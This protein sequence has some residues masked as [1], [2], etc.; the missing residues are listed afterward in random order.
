MQ[1]QTLVTVFF[2]TIGIFLLFSCQ[3][4]VI[5]SEENPAHA[6]SDTIT[7]RASVDILYT[8]WVPALYFSADQEEGIPM[9]W[10][11][12]L[13]GLIESEATQGYYPAL[14]IQNLSSPD[15]SILAKQIYSTCFD[16]IEAADSV[17]FQ[18]P[19]TTGLSFTERTKYIG[20]A[21]FFRAFNRFYLIR[22]FGSFPEQRTSTSYLSQETAY[23][24]V[25][26]D[27]QEAIAILPEKSFVENASRVTS[28]V[29]RALLGEVYLQMSGYP[30]QKKKYTEAAEILRPIIKSD[31]HHL[32]INGTREEAS[33][34]NILRTTPTNDEHLYVIYGEHTTPRSSF[35]FP[36][37]AKN[38]ENI[39]GNVA[40]NAFKPSKAFMTCYTN[41]DLRGKDRQFFHT[42]FKVKDEGK[43]IFE[44]FDPAPFFWLS[45]GT[46]TAAP[47]RQA[48]G[49]YRYA[50]ILLMTAEAIAQSEGGTAEA[51]TYLAQVRAR[52][53]SMP[54][55]ELEQYFLTLTTEHFLKEIWLERLRELPFEMKQ[56]SDIIRTDFYPTCQ[57]DTIC[58]VP[59]QEAQTPKGNP[60]NK[61]N[62]LLPRPIP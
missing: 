39:K 25:E 36:R 17:I 48:I 30:L 55:A 15:V 58:F 23:A 35:S 62:C 46:E 56:L 45:T 20:E 1:R 61:K 26:K 5:E 34:F 33:A 4:D 42:F 29:A 57:N 19:N 27:L 37:I 32:A 16:G 9:A 38:W 24:K 51:A 21:K 11:V 41:N 7:A 43:T 59:F 10:G 28:F 18:M 3:H 60:L 50:E 52:S 47:P 2:F 40:F 6:Y 12:Y 31:K 49:L 14:A 22:T 53:I 13:S 54:Q 8:K 44:I